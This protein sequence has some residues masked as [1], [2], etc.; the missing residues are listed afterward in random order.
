MILL[1]WQYWLEIYVCFHSWR[2][3]RLGGFME[4][5][6]KKC[7]RKPSLV[8]GINASRVDV[9]NDLANKLHLE[10]IRMDA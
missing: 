7:R 5:E 9:D 10:G 6:N 3:R 2:I 4:Q 8:F 1:Q